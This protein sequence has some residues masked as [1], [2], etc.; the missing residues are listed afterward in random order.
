MQQLRGVEL[1][2]FLRKTKKHNLEIYLCLENIQYAKNV[3]AIF[4]TAEAFKI[5]KIFLTGI[6]HTPPFGKQLKNASRNKEE[7]VPWEYI[8]DTG[9]VIQKMKNRDFDIVGLE[10]TDEAVEVKE[11]KTD[12]LLLIVGNEGYGIVKNTI[13]R[14]DSAVF[15]PMYGKGSSL[16]VSHA[17]GIALYSIISNN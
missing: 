17:T 3:A 14:M 4:R 7:K 11:L 1:K 16:N 5:K 6:S 10:I 8:K 15:I 13:E 9:A 2:R 12:K